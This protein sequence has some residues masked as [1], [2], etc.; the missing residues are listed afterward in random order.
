MAEFIDMNGYGFYV[1]GSYL[2]TGVLMLFEIILIRRRRAQ[3][4]RRLDRIGRMQAHEHEMRVDHEN[5][6]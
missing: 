1:W 2:V 4:R 6:A 3:L 5:E